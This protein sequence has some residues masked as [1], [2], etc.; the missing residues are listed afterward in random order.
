MLGSVLSL[1]VKSYLVLGIGQLFYILVDLLPSSFLIT[2]NNGVL[3][4]AVIV[5]LSNSHFNT[6]R[7]IFMDLGALFLYTQI[8]YNYVFLMDWPFCC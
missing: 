5:E 2:I 8:V 7:L 3:E 4:L 6:V 1:P